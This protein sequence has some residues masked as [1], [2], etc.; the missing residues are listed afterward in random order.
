MI[1]KNNEPKISVTEEIILFIENYHPKSSD[2][3]LS[4]IFLMRYFRYNPND[5]QN[6]RLHWELTTTA[7]S[8]SELETTFEILENMH[9]VA[10]TDGKYLLTQ[11]GKDLLQDIDENVKIA[12]GENFKYIKNRSE[13]TIISQARG[14]FFQETSFLLTKRVKM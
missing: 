2:T 4:A 6:E 3:I 1:G 9:C 12:Y 8:S 13:K 10:S 14:L 5:N 11:K 7:V